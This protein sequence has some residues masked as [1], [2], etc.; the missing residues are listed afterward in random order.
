HIE[1]QA[2]AELQRDELAWQ[3][4]HLRV[5]RDKTQT[6]LDHDRLR[7]SGIEEHRRQLENRLCQI[8]DN[9]N[10]LNDGTA[11]AVTPPEAELTELRSAI[12]V[13]RQKLEQLKNR[14]ASQPTTYS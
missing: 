12:N 1:V 13:A 7:L 10:Q 8:Q 11:G 5:S 14:V 2:D 9:T 4:G 3:L 6:D